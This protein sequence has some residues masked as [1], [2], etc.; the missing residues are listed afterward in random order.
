MKF[1][2]AK[3]TVSEIEI[4]PPLFWKNPNFESYVGFLNDS[5]A[6]EFQAGSS[7]EYITH[8]TPS[9]KAPSILEAKEKW[10]AI[11]EEM[12]LAA[13]EK[14]LASLSLRPTL[15]TKRLINQDDLAGIL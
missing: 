2:I 1:N 4:T 11:P 7:Y 10:I 12:F 3:N 8:T 13:H 14:A 6:V 15:V 5:C 9:I